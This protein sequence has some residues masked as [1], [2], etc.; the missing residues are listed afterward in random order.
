MNR[1]FLLMTASAFTGALL[2]IILIL[3][4]TLEA[5]D[6]ARRVQGILEAY[7]PDNQRIALIGAGNENQG[8]LFLFSPDGTI[9]HQLGSYGSGT[10]QGQS[11]MGLHG[12]DGSLRYLLRLH[13]DK[14]SPALVMKDKAGRD[15][16]VIGL[17]GADETPYISYTD[18]KGEQRSLIPTL[19]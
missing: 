12:R 5:R 8:T 17:S 10:E 16:L 9:T 18:A 2:A 4:T 14:D 19:P 3:P 13:G 15:K 1:Q 6:T 7:N 11:L